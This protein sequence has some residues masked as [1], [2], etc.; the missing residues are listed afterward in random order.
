[1]TTNTFTSN[2]LRLNTLHSQIVG[3]LK[4]L[5]K[6]KAIN[7]IHIWDCCCDHGYLGEMFL[8]NLHNA[9]VHF[10]DQVSTITDQLQTRLKDKKKNNYSIHCQD[11]GTLELN[12]NAIHIIM[13]AGV[14]GE[15]SIQLV[16]SILGNNPH[17]NHDNIFIQLC[18][19]YYVYDVRTYLH[20][21]QFRIVDETL[22]LDKKHHYEII[23]TSTHKH[24]KQH[25]IVS[26][27]GEFWGQTKYKPQQYLKKLLRHYEQKGQA[28]NRIGLKAKDIFQAYQQVQKKL[29]CD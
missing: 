5:T 6:D 22:I 13:I 9:N 7:N 24:F 4:K 12:D 14:G 11:A 8:N 16:E 25:S 3:L 17:I 2:N 18:P 15:L 23:L 29:N 20:N 28:K 27:T 21:K 19:N 1:M 26:K 10:V